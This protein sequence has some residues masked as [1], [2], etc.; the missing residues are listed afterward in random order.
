MKTKLDTEQFREE[1]QI[2]KNMRPNV[3]KL[4]FFRSLS[5][6]GIVSCFLS[7]CVGGGDKFASRIV[8]AEEFSRSVKS[9]E[10]ENFSIFRVEKDKERELANQAQYQRAAL[11]SES[12]KEFSG[13][14]KYLTK[15]LNL[16]KSW[17]APTTEFVRDEGATGEVV[18][19]VKPNFQPPHPP[20]SGK[21]GALL[22][23]GSKSP[24]LEGQMT[25]NPSLWPD[26]GQGANLFNDFRAFQPMDVITINIKESSEGKKKTKTG[27]EGKFEILAGIKSLFGL[28]TKAWKSN[29]EGLDPESLVA[30]NTETKFEGKG[31]TNRS[32]TM[33]AQL[34]AVIMEVLPNGL[35]RV[36]GTKIVSVDEEE[37]VM[38]I[39]GLVRTRDVDAQN[40]V[41]SNR[42]ANMRIDFYGRGVL[43]EQ[44]SAGW[45]TKLFDMIW[46]F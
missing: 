31:E 15:G 36:E 32:G 6:L 22:P 45:G 34:S 35:M 13:D 43:G 9:G 37:E 19:E 1:K 29:N 16:K 38:V 24:Y 10:G 39:S 33:K 44:Q 25:S 26:E 30:A 12:E 28:E 11:K 5:A 8:P 4:K 42:V 3:D 27:T 20:F 40:Q 46:P 41:E 2:L 7:S 14:E 23:P 21:G 18:K 17:A